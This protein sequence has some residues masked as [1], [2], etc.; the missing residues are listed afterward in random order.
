MSLLRTQFGNPHG[1][2][3]QLVGISMLAENKQRIEWALKVLNPQPYDR[4]L[5]IGFGPGWSIQ[6]LSQKVTC[7]FVAGLDISEVMLQQASKR[8]ADAI[9]ARQVELRLGSVNAIPYPDASFP[10][11]LVI[12]SLHHWPAPETDGLSEVIRVLCPSGSITL[13]EQP[14]HLDDT[15]RMLEFKDNIY[16]MLE[17]VGFGDISLRIKNVKNSPCLI[18]QASKGSPVD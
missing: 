2:V 1:F 5:E 15:E 4:I 11:A 8:N 17:E 12:N 7:G 9:Q 13:V 6:Q 16:S 14:R 10:K 18:F 3:G